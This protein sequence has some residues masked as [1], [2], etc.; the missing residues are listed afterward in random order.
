MKQPQ[1]YKHKKKSSLILLLIGFSVL[2]TSSSSFLN[3]KANKNTSH[4]EDYSDGNKNLNHFFYQLD[5]IQTKK[6]N[7]RIAFFGDSF[8]EGDI[9]TGELRKLLQSKFGGNGVGFVPLASQTSGFRSTIK[10]QHK[11]IT[12][13]N[14]VFNHQLNLPFATGGYYF[15]PKANNSINY[16]LHKPVN[17]IRLF[18]QST[19]NSTFYYSTNLIK[20]KKN[21]LPP[22]K[23]LANY[24]FSEKNVKSVQLKLSISNPT[25]IYGL[26]FED[27]VGI[28]LDN[29]GLRSNSGVGI[30][31]ITD[32]K[33]REFDSLQNYKLIILQYGLNAT[34]KNQK[35][36]S[37]YKK[38]ME[39]LIHRIKKNYKDA[40]IV[41]FSVSDRCTLQNGKLCTL[42]SIPLMVENQREIAKKTGVIF[43]NLF[44]AM[45]GTNSIIKFA[46]SKPSLAAGDYTHLTHKGGEYIARIFY[47]ELI[48]EYDRVKQLNTSIN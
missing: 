20:D 47:D 42:N 39:Q 14:V 13:Y 3:L 32:I 1:T 41:L 6:S 21:I 45:G 43:W 25:S 48:K 2:C 11:N 37:S 4:F 8:V 17:K 44:Q 28:I 22:S 29:F 10:H 34:S 9:L 30:A 46:K 18:Y 15:I 27:T 33:H 19:S 12:S 38:K 40:T 35:N 36:F 26:S 7:V 31:R 23:S 5:S 24:T 16:T